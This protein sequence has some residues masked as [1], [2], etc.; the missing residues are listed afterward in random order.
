MYIHHSALNS[1]LKPPKGLSSPRDAFGTSSHV[2]AFLYVFLGEFCSLKSFLA[3][4]LL[5]NREREAKDS[6]K[7]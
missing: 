6:W 7:H 5:S 4:M 3:G 2:E 1:C